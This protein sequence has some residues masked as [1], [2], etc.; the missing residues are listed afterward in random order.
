MGGEDFPPGRNPQS[1]PHHGLGNVTI[2]TTKTSKTSKS[3][4]QYFL[5]GL[6]GS[7]AA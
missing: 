4:K 2:E 3:L 1:P 7:K 5:R 6:C